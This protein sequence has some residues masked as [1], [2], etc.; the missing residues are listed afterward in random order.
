[1]NQCPFGTF[2]RTKAYFNRPFILPAANYT[3]VYPL[4]CSFARPGL[5]R[6]QLP[7]TAHTMRKPKAWPVS[8]PARF[9]PSIAPSG[10]QKLKNKRD[11]PCSNKE[12]SHHT[13]TNVKKLALVYPWHLF[14]RTALDAALLVVLHARQYRLVD[15]LTLSST[16]IVVLLLPVHCPLLHCSQELIGLS[17]VLGR[18][19]LDA[20]GHATS[21]LDATYD[22][23][24]IFTRCAHWHTR[25]HAISITHKDNALYRVSLPL[26]AIFLLLYTGCICRHR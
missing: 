1:M 11:P 14:V 25:F 5:R 19:T 10:L 4:T 18:T 26:H 2:E 15:A 23:S 13:G 12:K 6:G 20:P 7:C 21:D 17:S 22:S 9:R 16:T 24:W 3:I 8:R